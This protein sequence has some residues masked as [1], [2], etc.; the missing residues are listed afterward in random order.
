MEK[1][2]IVHV[3]PP[4]ISWNREAEYIDA[5]ERAYASGKLADNMKIARETGTTVEIIYYR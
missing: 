5:T 3:I 1:E 4:C 2:I